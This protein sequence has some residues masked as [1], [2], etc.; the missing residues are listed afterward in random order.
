MNDTEYFIG[1][2]IG[3]ERL[4]VS[5]LTRNSKT[6]VSSNCFDNNTDGFDKMLS[7]MNKRN[8]TS[9]NSIVCMESTGVYS[10]GLAYF[11]VT[12]R[13]RVCVEPPLKVKRAFPTHGHKNDITDSEHLAEYA[14]RFYDELHLWKPPDSVLEQLKTLLR[15]RHQLTR[16]KTSYYNNLT[17][18]K[19]ELVRTHGRENVYRLNRRAKQSDKKD[20]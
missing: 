2:D 15:T 12:H 1:V 19:R 17:A 9:T 6:P 5:V 8:V 7:W 16:N 3:S 4:A 14:C 11:L 18:M 20:R 13:Y 10:Q